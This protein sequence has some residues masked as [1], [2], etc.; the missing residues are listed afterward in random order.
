MRITAEYIED[1]AQLLVRL[2]SGPSP[3]VVQTGTYVLDGTPMIPCT[4]LVDIS[5]D[6][7]KN[8]EAHVCLTGYW[9][10]PPFLDVT[11]PDLSVQRVKPVQVLMHA[12]T[13]EPVLHE[14]PLDALTPIEPE[15][16]RPAESASPYRPEA[17]RPPEYP[18]IWVEL[19]LE[20][21]DPVRLGA[22]MTS[23]PL[24]Y[25]GGCEGRALSS[26]TVQPAEDAPPYLSYAPLRLEGQFS[27]S[28]FNSSF[29]LSPSWPSPHFDPLP[30]QWSVLLSDPMCSLRMQTSEPGAVL[31]SF[32]LR[33]R[34]RTGSDVSS[35]T[36]VTV[37][38]PA[39]AYGG[40]TFMAIL[41]PGANNAQGRVRLFTEDEAIS[42]SHILTPGQASAVL[43]PIETHTGRVKIA[44]DQAKGSGEEQVLQ[45]IAPALSLYSGP[46]SRIPTGKTSFADVLTLDQIEFGKPW[47]FLKGSVRVD[48]S[49]ESPSQPFSW[50]IM[51]GAQTLL[52]VDAGMLGSDFSMQ[53][54]PLALHL[55]SVLSYTLS[56]ASPSSFKLS[57]P[58]G[59][60]AVLPFALDL[61]SA[62]GSTAP[63]KV[64]L[65]GF[66]PGSG[67]SIAKRWAF[68][69]TQQ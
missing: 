25:S 15:M 53:S 43:L 51:L 54:V 61:S 31:P 63:L 27:N 18:D 28:L 9:P 11:L 2:L 64:E 23:L 39:A 49:G 24:S 30:D 50:K 20:R 65:A 60:F 40:E 56:W 37:L 13:W 62:E 67:S 34:Q 44:W 45:I 6:D 4:V 32:T 35:A 19:G 1:K 52:K 69:P 8:G 3:D 33:Y 14:Q 21:T 26:T 68:L 17:A 38:S 47:Y 58:D 57:D 42:S 12:S 10:L 41:A 22:G 46:H 5:S 55:S 48:G 36:P 29:A 16:S 66:R 7:I 59:N